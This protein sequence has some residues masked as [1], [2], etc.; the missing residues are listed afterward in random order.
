MQQ[1][2]LMQILS[3]AQNVL[4]TIMPV[5]RNSRVLYSGCCLWYL[6]L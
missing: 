5:I 2:F 3:L 1:M 6:V 4:G